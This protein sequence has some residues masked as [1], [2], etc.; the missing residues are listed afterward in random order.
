MGI[1]DNIPGQD[2]FDIL[3]ITLFIFVFQDDDKIP[4]ALSEAELNLKFYFNTNEAGTY[5]FDS[6]TP[7]GTGIH[8]L[9]PIAPLQFSGTADILTKQLRQQMQTKRIC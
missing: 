2:S 9:V 8:H 6:N 1:A 4:D 7:P 3:V 5:G